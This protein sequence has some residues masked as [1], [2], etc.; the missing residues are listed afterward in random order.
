MTNRS[1]NPRIPKP[2]ETTTESTQALQTQRELACDEADRRYAKAAYARDTS[3]LRYTRAKQ[4]ASDALRVAGLVPM[5][6][7]TPENARAIDAA[8]DWLEAR[9]SGHSTDELVRLYAQE[10]RP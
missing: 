8:A 7:N 4:E 1:A 5:D 10:V 9:L 2:A 3:N 6:R